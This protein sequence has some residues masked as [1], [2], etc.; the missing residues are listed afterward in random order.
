MESACIKCILFIKYCFDKFMG[1]CDLYQEETFNHTIIAS[2]NNTET[3]Q[4]DCVRQGL[5]VKLL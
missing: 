1:I 3:R 5:V 4:N 2:Q